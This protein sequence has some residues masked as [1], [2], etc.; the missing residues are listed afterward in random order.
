MPD[1]DAAVGFLR[2]AFGCVEAYRIGPFASDDDWMAR[3]LGVAPEAR[4]PAIAV[5]SCAD[6]ARLEVFQYEAPDQRREA[7]RNSDVGGHHVAF[8]TD[9]L[10]AALDQVRAAGGEVMG[11]PTVM[12]AGSSRGETWVYVRSPWGGQF[13]LVTRGATFGTGSEAEAAAGPDAP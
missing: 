10:P 7:P 3:H 12:T 9:D 5:L 11:S 8:Y 13:E 2:D 4:I 1:L 6:G